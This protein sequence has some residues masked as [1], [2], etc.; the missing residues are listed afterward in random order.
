M[1]TKTQLRSPTNRLYNLIVK[2]GA[3]FPGLLRWKIAPGD[4]ARSYA[5]YTARGQ[6]RKKPG[7]DILASFTMEF[8]SASA[9]YHG[10]LLFTL[11]ASVTGALKPNVKLEDIPKNYRRLTRD[12]LPTKAYYYDIE[13]ESPTGFVL[14][15][16]EGSVLVTAEVT[17]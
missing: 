11:P 10:G 8:V 2:Q 16:I 14:R 7:G 4:T 17:A 12:L 15:E 3:D 1:A 5:G 6:I 13:T 9:D